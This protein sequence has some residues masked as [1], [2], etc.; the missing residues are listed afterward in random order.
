MRQAVAHPA[1]APASAPAQTATSQENDLGV[2]YENKTILVV[3]DSNIVRNFVKRI[4]D[5]VYDI[6]VA[7]DGEEA[8]NILNYF[9]S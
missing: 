2:V 6:G 7:K 1:S 4:F 9:Y 3:D 8:I 5:G